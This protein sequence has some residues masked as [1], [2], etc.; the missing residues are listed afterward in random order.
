MTIDERR[1]RDA[2]QALFARAGI[3]PEEHRVELPRLGTT[4]R[5]LEHGAG[6]PAVFLPGG[7][8]A[9]STFATSSPRRPRS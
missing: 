1:Y 7:P 2:E 5:V 9:A 4:V 6:D 3:T 8:N